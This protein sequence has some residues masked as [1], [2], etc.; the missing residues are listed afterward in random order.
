MLAPPM[1]RDAGGGRIAILRQDDL[2]EQQTVGAES[3][4]DGGQCR[5]R[6]DEEAGRDEQQRGKRDLESDD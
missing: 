3:G 2:R 5:K 1:E 4:I 6:T